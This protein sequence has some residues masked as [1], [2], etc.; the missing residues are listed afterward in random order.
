MLCVSKI[1]HVVWCTHVLLL[2]SCAVCEN[3]MIPRGVMLDDLSF[4]HTVIG[5]FVN[6][7][8]SNNKAQVGFLKD[9]FKYKRPMRNKTAEPGRLPGA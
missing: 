4:V 3:G 5:K 1:V 7:S 2:A 8:L 9:R 6:S